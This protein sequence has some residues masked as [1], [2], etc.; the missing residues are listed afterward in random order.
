MKELRLAIDVVPS[1]LWGANPRRAMERT[2]WDKLRK[3]VCAD[4]GY[5]CGICGAE[6]PLEVHE[7]WEYDDDALVQCLVGFIALCRPCHQIKHLG[8]SELLAQEGKVDVEALRRHFMAVNGCTGQEF[9]EHRQAAFR[10]WRRRSA[11]GGWTVN[12]GPYS[13]LITVG[14]G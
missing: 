9:A 11:Q 6:G 2:K 13:D 7:R 3:R 12:W 5:R 1:P 4:C 10:V 14:S 8:R